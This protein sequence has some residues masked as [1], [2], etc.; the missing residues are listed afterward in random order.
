[1]MPMCSLMHNVVNQSIMLL[2]LVKGERKSTFYRLRQN[3]QSAL[4][5]SF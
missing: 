2:K 5:D 4:R 3:T 1:M